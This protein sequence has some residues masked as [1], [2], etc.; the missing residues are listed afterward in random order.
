MKLCDYAPFCFTYILVKAIELFS[1]DDVNP[2][3]RWKKY[4]SEGY[5]QENYYRSMNDMK[6]VELSTY[7]IM[8]II[9]NVL[10]IGIVLLITILIFW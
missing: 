5:T 10:F 8:T 9:P 4:F 6:N 7:Y 3:V 2:D 1:G